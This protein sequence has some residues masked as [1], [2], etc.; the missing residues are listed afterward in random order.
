MDI[1]LPVLIINA[2]TI[3]SFSALH[4]LQHKNLLHNDLLFQDD[5]LKFHDFFSPK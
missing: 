4:K 3:L 5:I 2:K 1:K